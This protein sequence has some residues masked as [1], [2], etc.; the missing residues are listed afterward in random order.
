[1]PYF[2]CKGCA[3]RWYSAV[4]ET[5]CAECGTPLGRD[6]WMLEETPRAQPRRSMR[7]FAQ[8]RPQPVDERAPA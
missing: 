5:R 6:E 4:S 1:M 3:L 7:P 8:V 2:K